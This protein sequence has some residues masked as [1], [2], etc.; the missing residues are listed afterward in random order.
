MT[1]T[2]RFTRLWLAAASV[3]VLA[4][5]VVPARSFNTSPPAQAAAPGGSGTMDYTVVNGVRLA[6]RVVGSGVPVVFI[7]GESHSHEVWREQ[8][9]A[10]SARHT[11]VVYDRRGHGQSE[12]P[13]TGYSPIAHMHDLQG[14]MRF[15]GLSDAHFVVSSRGGAI[16]LQLLRVE[17]RLVRSV[18]FADA[19]I[20]IVP[21]SPAFAAAVERYRRPAASRAEAARERAARKQAPFYK[22]A[23]TVPRVADVM[24]RMIDQHSLRIAMNPRRGSDLTSA[25]DIGPWNSSDFPDMVK[26]GTPVLIVVGAETDPLFLTAAEQAAAAWPAARRVVVPGVDHLLPLEAPDT[27]NPLIT[28]FFAAA[29]A[30]RTVGG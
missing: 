1:G 24:S 15:L 13:F 23:R 6:F 28:E 17:P 4:C 18:V 29:D 11:A 16:V 30:A 12:A 14:L 21:L 25:M 27:F 3:S 10:V 5:L 26:L 2:G 7:H 22:V 20:P 9:D 8:I 19:T